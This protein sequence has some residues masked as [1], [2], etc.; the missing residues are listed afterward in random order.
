MFYGHDRSRLELNV[1]LYWQMR[2]RTRPFYLWASYTYRIGSTL[3]YSD[4]A[5]FK[6]RSFFYVLFY[7]SINTYCEVARFDP[8]QR[9]RRDMKLRN[10][11]SIRIYNNFGKLVC[12]IHFPRKNVNVL[13]RI[14]ETSTSEHARNSHAIYQ[15]WTMN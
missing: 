13:K 11:F 15:N 1:L 2:Q 7:I 9:T 8:A 12:I 10:S 4:R 3:L 6:D 5:S 14:K